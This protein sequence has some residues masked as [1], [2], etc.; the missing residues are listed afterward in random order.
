MNDRHDTELTPRQRAAQEAVRG[1]ARPTADPDFRRRLKADFVAGAIAPAA[2]PAAGGAKVLRLVVPALAAAAMI[3]VAV[4]GLGSRPGPELAGLDGDGRVVI[5]GAV[6]ADA[7]ALAASLRPGARVELQGDVTLEV[8][9]PGTLAWRLAP[10]TVFTLPD[11]PGRFLPRRLR[12]E[13][14]FG[15]VSVRTGPDFAGNALVVGTGEGDAVITGTLVDVF[16]N[17]AVTCICLIEGSC[18]VVSDGRDL[19]A[20]D[21][22]MRWVLH[23][24][25]ADPDLLDIA[26]PHREHM[27]ALECDRGFDAD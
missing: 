24:D 7:D 25:G 23:R 27:E 20:L 5:D 14:E 21:P 3:A 4:I 6:M 18:R 13:L 11:A 26:P 17:E 22:G 16:R 2:R 12:A 8:L 19:G 9:Y 1:L 10:G 15:E